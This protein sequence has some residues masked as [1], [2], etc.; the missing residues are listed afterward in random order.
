MC[1]DRFDG[2]DLPLTHEFLG[3]M[4]GVRR[5]SVTL[6]IQVLEGAG[7]IRARPADRSQPRQA[8]RDRGRQLRAA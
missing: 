1:R 5:S 4:L 8:R 2:D 3:I 6:A 7:V